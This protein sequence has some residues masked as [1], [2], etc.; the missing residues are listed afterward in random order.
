[1]ARGVPAA[2]YAG[3]YRKGRRLCNSDRGGAA[4]TS[5]ILRQQ[6]V[7]RTCQRSG[8]GTCPLHGTLRRPEWRSQTV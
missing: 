5:L 6:E 7:Q 8:S 3:R 4:G 2:C 1:M